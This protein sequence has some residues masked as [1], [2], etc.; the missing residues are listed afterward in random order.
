MCGGRGRG[1]GWGIKTSTKTFH[2][3]QQYVEISLF[4]L[5]IMCPGLLEEDVNCEIRVLFLQQMGCELNY[6][7]FFS[8]QDGARLMM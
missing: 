5:D 8:Q 1:W 7:S 4:A 3:I 2:C 6:M